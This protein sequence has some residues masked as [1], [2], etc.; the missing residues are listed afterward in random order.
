MPTTLLYPPVSRPTLSTSVLVRRQESLDNL[1]RRISATVDRG[2]SASVD[3][4]SV[5]LI[6]CHFRPVMKGRLLTRIERG[7]ILLLVGGLSLAIWL[8]ARPAPVSAQATN[9]QALA[10]SAESVAG[11]AREY[12]E[13]A[14]CSIG[15]QWKPAALFAHAHPLFW[16]RPTAVDHNMLVKQVENGL[17]R[18]A[19]HGSVLSA[20][21]FNTP[22]LVTETMP[23]GGTVQ[24]CAVSGQ[25]ECADG[26]V[27]RFAA[28]LIQN[29]KSQ[30]WGIADLSVPPFLI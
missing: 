7:L 25:I 18:L 24:T 12:V 27:L 4:A 8:H 20:P 10:L 19:V 14:L 29:G 15:S 6:S 11:T 5:K 3:R 17:A 2:I 1:L 23:D 26:V 21:I 30:K 22:V 16:D 13:T 9:Y 28:R